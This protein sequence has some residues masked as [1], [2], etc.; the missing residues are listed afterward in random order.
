[1]SKLARFGGPRTISENEL[2]KGIGKW[3][4]V[5]NKDIEAVVDVLRLEG[6]LWGFLHPVVLDFQKKYKNYSKRKYCLAVSSGTVALQL[7]VASLDITAGS[8]IIT[9][10]LGYISSASCILHQNCIPVF[11]DISPDTFNIDPEKIEEKITEKTKAI[12]AVDLHGLPAPYKELQSI[13]KRHNLFI[14]EDASQAQGASYFGTPAGGLGDIS[15][16][17]IMP[18]KNL[19]SCGE[20]GILTTDNDHIRNNMLGFAS[21]G[22]FVWEEEAK[23]KTRIS[24]QLGFNCRPTPTSI[25]FA[26]RQLSRLK[27]YKTMRK[28][29]ADLFTSMVENISFIRTPFIPKGYEHGYQMYRLMVCPEALRLPSDWAPYLRDALV[30]LLRAEGV[31][32]DFWEEQILPEMPIFLNKIGYGNG[33]PWTCQGATEIDNSIYKEAKKVFESSFFPFICR[34]TNSLNFVKLQAE[35]FLK[36]EKYKDDLVDLTEE[37]ANEGGFAEWSGVSIRNTNAQGSLILI[38]DE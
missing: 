30:F 37:I 9:P 12:V 33:C 14:I 29:R 32:C 38:R 22:M 34:P 25:A 24:R 10:A 27:K 16:I 13:A 7:A 2:R 26:S 20:G 23:K 19:P 4:E 6:E 31:I 5:T 35:G 15:A 28:K 11:S 18:S 36:V 8:E 1:M 21:H 17:S 3:P